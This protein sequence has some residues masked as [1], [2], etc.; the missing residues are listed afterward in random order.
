MPDRRRGD[1]ELVGDDPQRNTCASEGRCLGGSLVG[2]AVD[3]SLGYLQL[4][5]GGGERVELLT[6]GDDLGGR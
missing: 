3:A 1:T 4:A 6:E 5:L 2:Q